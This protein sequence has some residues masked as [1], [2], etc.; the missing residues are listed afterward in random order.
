[1]SSMLSVEDAVKTPKSILTKYFRSLEVRLVTFS[2]DRPM[3]ADFVASWHFDRLRFTN[4]ITF[5]KLGISS[6]SLGQ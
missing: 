4:P 1:M 5:R 3:T 6:F 2:I